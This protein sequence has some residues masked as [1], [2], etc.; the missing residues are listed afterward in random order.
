MGETEQ[1]LGEALGDR[2]ISFEGWL[3]SAIRSDGRFDRA[4]LR[5]IEKGIEDATKRAQQRE[6]HDGE[7][8]SKWIGTSGPTSPKGS[9]PKRKRSIDLSSLGD[10]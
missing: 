3:A 5:A 8:S 2:G 10:L 1:I 7:L 4:A 9:V 6:Q